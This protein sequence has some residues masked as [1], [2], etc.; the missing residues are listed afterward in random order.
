MGKEYTKGK[1]EGLKIPK[2]E[3]E[4]MFSEREDCYKTYNDNV[5]YEQLI[6]PHCN[7]KVISQ[8]CLQLSSVGIWEIVRR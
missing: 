8:R 4:Q 5:I 3:Q 7:K 2:A 1:F 6:C